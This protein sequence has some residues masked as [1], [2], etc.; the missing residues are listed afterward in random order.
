MR[1]IASRIWPS[2]IWAGA[3]LAFG[4][5]VSAVPSAQAASAPAMAG[6]CASCHG[7]NGISPY[8]TYPNLA[9]QKEG[10][11]AYA[12]HQYQTHQRLGQQAA[13][14]SGVAS[15]LS[16]DDINALAAY[17]ASLSP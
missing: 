1:N 14:M 16:A 9:G 4:L 3:G 13:I 5:A 2:T 6:V 17:Y 15:H 8:P 12:L 11:L 7:T 10:Y